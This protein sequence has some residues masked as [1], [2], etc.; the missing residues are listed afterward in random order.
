M[1]RFEPVKTAIIGSGMISDIYLKNLIERFSITEVM[2]CA[3]MVEEKARAQAEKYNIRA[4][5][6]DQI[7]HDPKIEMVLNLTYATSHYEIS[8]AVLSAKNTVIAKR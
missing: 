3:D 5:T 2:A 1:M 4:M 6:V 7:L 8:K